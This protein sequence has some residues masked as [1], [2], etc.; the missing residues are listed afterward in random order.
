MKKGLTRF[1]VALAL[2]VFMSA[3]AVL[4]QPPGPPTSPP[5]QGQ[6][7]GQGPDEPNGLCAFLDGA[8]Q[9]RLFDFLILLFGCP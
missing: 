4:A 2:A 7:Q 5:G 3:G 9:S 6:G 8:P 1:G